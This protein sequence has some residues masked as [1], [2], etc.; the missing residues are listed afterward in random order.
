[1]FIQLN[2]YSTVVTW[3]DRH[4]KVSNS[5]YYPVAITL[6]PK[7]KYVFTLDISIIIQMDMEIKH[8]NYQMDILIKNGFRCKITK[9]IFHLKRLYDIVLF[10]MG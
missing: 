7:G 5:I 6:P 10:I 2:Y 9:W 1:M 4:F 3:V 8:I